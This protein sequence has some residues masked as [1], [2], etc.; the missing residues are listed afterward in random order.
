MAE[1]LNFVY[2]LIHFV[3]LFLIVVKGHDQSKF[4]LKFLFIL[5]TIFHFLWNIYLSLFYITGECYTNYDC[6]VKYSCPYKHMVK[7]VGGY[8]LGFR[9]D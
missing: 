4:I 5:Y 2:F 7:C 3:S 6:C 8:C 9:N 1:I